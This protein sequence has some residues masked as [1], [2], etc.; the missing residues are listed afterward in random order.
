M[1]TTETKTVNYP[2]SIPVAVVAL[3]LLVM[4]IFFL[5]RYCK[6]RKIKDLA[7]GLVTADPGHYLNMTEDPDDDNDE[8]L[9][10]LNKDFTPNK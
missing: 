2:V 8:P 5:V 3:I 10:D 1:E 9:I 4:F 6:D 7:P